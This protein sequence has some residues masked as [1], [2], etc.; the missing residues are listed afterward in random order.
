MCDLPVEKRGIPT[1]LEFL[2]PT[3]IHASANRALC[4]FVMSGS[5]GTVCSCYRIVEFATYGDMKNALEKL[6]D[7]EINGRR[8]RLIEDRPKKSKRRSAQ[9]IDL[10]GNLNVHTVQ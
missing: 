9:L 4:R 3:E 6:D 10:T 2:T 5:C 1:T 7:T 8:I